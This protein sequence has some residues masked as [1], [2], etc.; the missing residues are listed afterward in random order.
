MRKVRVVF[1]PE[2]E[3]VYRHLNEIAPNSKVDRSIL[4]AIIKK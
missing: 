3:E 1:S 4:N 2:A